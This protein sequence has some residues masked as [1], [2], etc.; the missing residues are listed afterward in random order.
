MDVEQAA[1]EH[2]TLRIWILDLWALFSIKPCKAFRIAQFKQT[3]LNADLN[4]RFKSSDSV[5][6]ET[7]VFYKSPLILSQKNPSSNT[8]RHISNSLSVYL[9]LD[10]EQVNEHIV[11]YHTLV[12][13][14]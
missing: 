5:L 3:L 9:F 14:D 7:I 10:S 1:F 2:L 8:F 13:Q 11:D 6:L 12:L 4:F